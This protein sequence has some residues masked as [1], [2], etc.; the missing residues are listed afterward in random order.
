MLLIDPIGRVLHRS[1]TLRIFHSLE[2]APLNV[3]HGIVVHQTDSSSAA[4]TLDQYGR[5]STIGAH[6]LIDKDGTTYQT[7]SVRHR[8]RHVGWLKPRCIAEHRCTPAELSALRG[9][10]LGSGI[11][12]VEAAKPFPL[13]FPGNDDALGIEVVGKAQPTPQGDKYEVLTAAQQ[14]SLRWLVQAL[15]LALAVPMR[16]VYRHPEVSWKTESE[17]SSAKWN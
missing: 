1:I 11:G 9:K 7:A 2:G 4:S 12:R 16:E 8:T 13:R 5:G 10:R 14:G 17:A 15:S 3:V 6:F